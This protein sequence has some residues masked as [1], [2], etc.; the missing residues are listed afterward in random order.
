M[1]TKIKRENGKVWLE[2]VQGWLVGDKESSVHAAQEAA[3]HAVG[4]QI[5]YHTLLGVSGLAFRM[6]I[7][8][9]GLCPSSPHSCCGFQCVKR[10]TQA[11]PWEI[12]IYQ[13]KPEDAA[14][15]SRARKAV[16]ESIE[17][18]V[19]V[20]YG[21]EED[22][23][24]IG[25]QKDGQEWLVLHPYKEGSRT[26]VVETAWPW[27]I[28]VFTQPKT[29]LADPFDL[30]QGAFRQVVEMAHG[31]ES[32]GYFIGFKA[33]DDY[34]AKLTTLLEASP[35]TRQENMLGNAWIYECLIQYRRSAAV[36][37]RRTAADFPGLG[38]SHLHKAASLYEQ[39]ADRVLCDQ[40][41]CLTAI[42]P[43]PWMLKEGE[44]WTAGHIEDQ[45]SRLKEALPL[46]REATADI[47][48][49]LELLETGE[50]AVS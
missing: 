40:E 8:K 11:L 13:V 9:D 2:G 18:G 27:G 38:A 49:A 44:S 4:E 24:I 3:M 35:E 42:A 15:V 25:Y 20:Q 41:N 16:V 7:S 39:M 26:M 46:E 14:G 36:Y 31:E 19:P 37:L 33:W 1:N 28:A 22:G 34:L 45:I 32:D 50:T 30:A 6:Q 29:E 47:E 21:S 43:Y 5:D 10:S 12:E 23:L 48:Q 17:R